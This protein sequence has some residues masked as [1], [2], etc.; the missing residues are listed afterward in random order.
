VSAETKD[1]IRVA[2][3]EPELKSQVVG[4]V[5]TSPAEKLRLFGRCG[6]ADLHSLLWLELWHRIF[7]ERSMTGR[8]S[9]K[10]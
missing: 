2:T 4:R 1:F 3:S 9:L 6:E 10:R 8:E 5:K 7:I